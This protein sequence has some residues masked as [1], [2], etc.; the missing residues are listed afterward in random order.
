MKNRRLLHAVLLALLI[1]VLV[2]TPVLYAQ[3][4]VTDFE[5]ARL[6]LIS[7][8][9][10]TATERELI[11]RARFL[12]ISVEGGVEPIRR[13]LYAHYG[14]Q[15][16]GRGETDPAQE[17][18]FR[19]EILSSDRFFRTAGTE[20]YTLL[21]GNVSLSVTGVSDTASMT[22]SAD[23]VL[24]NG[25]EDSITA[26][27]TV[28]YT[29]G[30]TA[31]ED[32]LSGN[33][34]TIGLNRENLYLT[35]GSTTMIRENSEGDSVE[36]FAS[37]SEV[38]FTEEPRTIS[39]SGGL[40]TTNPEQAY[41]S[42]RARDLYLVDG[43]DVFI[44]RATISLGRVPMLWVPFIYY[45]GKT[46]IFNPAIGFHSER[47]AFFSTSTELYGRYPKIERE[48]Q[49]SFSTLLGS[50]GGEDEKLMRDGWVYSVV[51]DEELTPLEKWADSSSSHFTILLDA[52][53]RRG[54]F[55]GLDTVNKFQ[56]FSTTINGFGGVAF[57]GA[58]AALLS[59]VYDIPSIRYFLDTSVNIDT[60][61]VDLSLYMPFYSDPKVLRDY[62]NRLTSFSVDALINDVQFPATYRSDITSFDWVLSSR[63]VFP[64]EWAKPYISTLRFDRFAA[65]VSWKA[66]RLAEGTG[67]EMTSFTVPD[68]QA[69]VAGTLF[70]FKSDTTGQEKVMTEPIPEPL[71]PA[72]EIADWG[73]DAPF[74]APRSTRTERAETVSSTSLQYS[75]RHTTTNTQDFDDGQI[76]DPSR[77]ARTTGSISLSSTI[78]PQILR[79]NQQI[80]PIVSVN[81]SPEKR[82]EQITVT[83]K[84]DVTL[85]ALGFSYG[86]T[87]RI[88]SENTVAE[89]S[90][91]PEVS[92]GWGAWDTNTITRH[93][94]SW[95][96]GF[97]VGRGVLTP[98]LT[99]TLAPLTYG[100]TPKGTYE[101]GRFRSSIAYRIAQDDDGIFRGEQADLTIAYVNRNRFEIS[102]QFSYDTQAFAPDIPWTDPLSLSHSVSL[103]LFDSYLIL[104]EHSTYDWKTNHLDS[105]SVSASLPWA[106]VRMDGDGPI[107]KPKVHLVDTEVSIQAYARSWW[108]NRIKLEFDVSSSYRHSFQYAYASKFTFGLNLSFKIEEFLTV[109]LALETVNNGFHRY[110]SF[111]EVWEDLLKSFDLSGDGRYQTQFTMDTVTFSLIH[112]MAD[113]DLHC[114]YEG[115]VVLS[116]MEWHWR[117]VFSVFLQWKAIPEIKV[118]REFDMWNQ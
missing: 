86:L 103:F 84:T 115:S 59:A 40:I 66:L 95:K 56:R 67:F 7:E 98:S 88:F 19:V 11:D 110:D 20:E 63:I 44:N 22:I 105:F 58:D 23:R 118:D 37:G 64:T 52:Y 85:P 38:F 69:Y 70:S 55:I 76:S 27:G 74:S 65:R 48:D 89:T 32:R 16:T 41:F 112:H 87:G 17:F 90:G 51:S 77:Y 8:E 107:E 34:V 35:D 6:L 83:S 24:L 43:G 80:D 39:F 106:R 93:Q 62:G 26:M 4:P 14:L 10:S 114:K 72:I 104:R 53:Q 50:S 113:W 1:F 111:N 49:S 108:K 81:L 29:S 33:M 9:I 75:L 117:P 47:G 42:I 82:T 21:E 45:P 91:V 12:G 36:F 30:G 13:R 5:A 102:S 73:I 28:R 31:I 109:E 18:S 71:D 57:A 92:G 61:S 116:D 68:L 46:F 96:Y 15:E 25:A 101:I 3:E 79:F 97:T 54:V 2:P 100:F 78:S 99:A 60:K 94:V